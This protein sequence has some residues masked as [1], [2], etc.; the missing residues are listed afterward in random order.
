MRGTWEDWLKM[1]IIFGRKVFKIN[2]FELF[3]M[4]WGRGGRDVDKEIN[5]Y[6]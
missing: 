3:I 1:I 2:G 6:E 5:L 4:S